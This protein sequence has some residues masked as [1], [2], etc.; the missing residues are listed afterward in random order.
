MVDES[1]ST[2][3]ESPDDPFALHRAATAVLDSSAVLTG[4]SERAQELLGYRPQEVLGRPA[5]E[6]LIDRDAREW[7][8]QV[9][10]SCLRGPGWFGMVPLRHREGGKVLLGIRARR[11]LRPGGGCDWYLVGAPAQGV[12]QWE[13]DRAVLDGLFRRS[14]IGFASHAPDLRVLRV[15][16]TLARV[17]GLPSAESARGHRI[18]DFLIPQDARQV[19]AG[20][21]R[22]L[23]TGTP[24]IFAEQPCRL[25]RDP[26]RERFVSVSAFRMVDSVGT[27]LGVAQLVEDVTERHRAQRRLALLNE[28]STRIGTTLDVIA[29]AR[30]LADVAVP[31]IADCITVDLLESVA[32]GGEPTPSA[33]GP[34]IRVAAKTPGSQTGQLLFPVG[35]S[36]DFPLNTPQHRCLDEL[37]PIL[38]RDF[39]S[40][41]SSTPAGARWPEYARRLG[42]RSLMAVP[43]IARGH[44]LGVISLWRTRQAELFEPDDLALAG[45][46]V[47]RAAACIDN[48]RRY[49]QQ[50]HAALVLQQSMLPSTLPGQLAV[51]VAHRYLPASS[52]SGVGG[53]WFDVIPL[54]GARVALV[55]GDVVGHGI[56]AAATMGRLRAAVQALANLDL[57]PD[58]VLTHL[59]DLVGRLADDP[60]DI[61]T[62]GSSRENLIGATC[63]YAVYDPVT[64]RCSL[65][66]AGHPPPIV[67]AADG[68]ASLVDLPAGPPLGLGGLPFEAAELHLAE[69]SLLALYSNGLIEAADRDIDD[70]LALLC[71]TLKAPH[72]S[73]E[74]IATSTVAALAPP[75]RTDDATLLIARTRA[76]S[77]DQV[78][79]W[80]LPR[81][82]QAAGMARTLV[83][84]QL[85]DWQLDAMVFTTELIATELVTNAY[86]Y[87]DGP[88]ELR[89][90][91][92]RTL[93]CEVSDGSTTAPHL[94]RARTTD[95]GGRGLFLVA[96]LTQR[97]GARCTREGKTVWT[98][99]PLPR[100][101]A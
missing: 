56:H 48:A 43:L 93:M 83:I 40:C 85:T 27:V 84:R 99:Q 24:M 61:D 22:V 15:N 88:I 38:E 59:D 11:V 29:T 82:P 91:I 65:A 17:S 74:E 12:V 14:P 44:I 64:T 10:A 25:R 31:S 66:R 55:V 67:V 63:L 80:R 100:S 90:I 36:I 9:T 72:V 76:L 16:R 58:D 86:R 78:A 69:G 41:L 3:G 75:P 8:T 89:L 97:W 20:L 60:E 81:E 73:L 42:I 23:E 21:A 1:V 49:T 46:F 52:A 45:E 62:S 98:E 57:E 96:Q 94:R 47:T 2:F 54:S 32:H 77:A 18:A 39:G 71:S 37:R 4:W 70:N 13:T 79:V 33:V 5:A 68:N 101:A 87:S 95:E 92:D 19:E 26:D 28:A 30:E 51:D 6:L 34:V 35:E 53:D 7:I 50:H